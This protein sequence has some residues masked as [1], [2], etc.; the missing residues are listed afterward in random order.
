MQYFT[1]RI[2]QLIARYMC[3]QTCLLAGASRKIS[4]IFFQ[5]KR[6]YVGNTENVTFRTDPAKTVETICGTLIL[7]VSLLVHA[8]KVSM[9]PPKERGP[10][11]FSVGN[12]KVALWL[13]CVCMS[14]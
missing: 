5:L 4:K 7:N 1:L 6:G 13:R 10:V 2:R 12:I 9:A 8:G 14:I 11:V 3:M